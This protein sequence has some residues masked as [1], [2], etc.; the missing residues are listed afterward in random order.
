MF[1]A[2]VIP[3]GGIGSGGVTVTAI[4]CEKR[5]TEL[6]FPSI[7]G[8]HRMVGAGVRT[9]RGDGRPSLYIDAALGSQGKP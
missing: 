6:M 1:A 8:A 5:R 2:E 4:R 3:V 9:D 7:D